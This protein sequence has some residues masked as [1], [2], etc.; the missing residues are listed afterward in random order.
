M[1]GLSESLAGTVS[2]LEMTTLSMREIKS[3]DFGRPF[4]PTEM[5]ISERQKHL[6]KYDDIW[7]F[8]HNGFYPEL[9]DDDPRNCI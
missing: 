7:S 4:I 5:Y 8:I 1:K 6:K 3:V 2:I 9:Y